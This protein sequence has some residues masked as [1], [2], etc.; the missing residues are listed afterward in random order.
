VASS[1]RDR[2]VDHSLVAIGEVGL[3]GEIRM[4]PRAGQRVREAVNL[5]LN[6][7]IVPWGNL[8]ELKKDPIKAE[9]IGVKNLS[10]AME[11]GLL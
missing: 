10:Q 11:V 5:G 3:T 1:F 4:V 2:S 6:K 8:A 9:L 7:V